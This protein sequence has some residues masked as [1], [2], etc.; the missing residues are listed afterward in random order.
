MAEHNKN[1]SRV[2]E[3]YLKQTKH[4]KLLSKEK[5]KEIALRIKTIEKQIFNESIYIW[6]KV[7]ISE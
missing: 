4:C 2:I 3:E 1:Y 7:S 6:Q 5:V